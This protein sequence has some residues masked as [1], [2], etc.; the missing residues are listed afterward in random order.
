MTRRSPSLAGAAAGDTVAGMELHC[1]TCARQRIFEQPACAE[2]PRATC[3]DRACTACGTAI[4][5]A[6]AILLMDRRARVFVRGRDD[7]RHAA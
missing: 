7:R 1:D 3:P 2:H 5:V 4:T 6:P